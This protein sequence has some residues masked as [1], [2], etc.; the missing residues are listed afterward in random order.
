V[1]SLSNRTKRSSLSQQ[2]K[3]KTDSQLSNFKLSSLS[4]SL[5]QPLFQISSLNLSDFIFC[6]FGMFLFIQVH[7]LGFEEAANQNG[8]V[9]FLGQFSE[10]NFT[11][12]FEFEF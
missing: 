5:S 8:E 12:N 10:C 7:K 4:L 3:L 6:F 2:V 11:F 1:K 9:R